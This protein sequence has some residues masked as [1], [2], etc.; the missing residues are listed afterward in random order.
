MSS[1][2]RENIKDLIKFIDLKMRPLHLWFLFFPVYFLSHF[3]LFCFLTPQEWICQLSGLN[4]SF[5]IGS[6][7]RREPCTCNVC[8]HRISL[9]NQ[10]RP[11]TQYYPAWPLSSVPLPPFYVPNL[12]IALTQTHARKFSNL[13]LKSRF[14]VRDDRGLQRYV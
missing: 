12:Y 8:I 9:Y 14:K 1:R 10:S 13:K 2:G 3:L 4:S 5:V 6:T 11:C 7:C